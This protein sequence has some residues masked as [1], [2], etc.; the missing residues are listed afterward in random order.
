MRVDLVRTSALS[1]NLGFP[2]VFGEQQSVS[3]PC[4]HFDGGESGSGV[5]ARRD[6]DR[7][8]FHIR[9]G[10]PPLHR[11][12][13]TQQIRLHQP[14]NQ[15]NQ[16]GLNNS[17]PTKPLLLHSHLREVRWCVREVARV[18]PSDGG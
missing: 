14:T 15:T 13:E 3:P 6:V 4:R 7:A 10:E 16:G 12:D 9:G 17:P 11:L 2:T 1:L 5:Q 8:L 18:R